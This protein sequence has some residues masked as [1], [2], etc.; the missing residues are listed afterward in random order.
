MIA[1]PGDFYLG[2]GYRS[3]FDLDALPV[4]PLDRLAARFEEGS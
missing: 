2:S 1:V 3:G 4:W